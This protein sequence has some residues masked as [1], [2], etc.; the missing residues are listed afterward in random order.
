[1]ETLKIPSKTL[2]NKPDPAVK[3]AGYLGGL[4][5]S[6]VGSADGLNTV[7]RFPSSSATGNS[8]ATNS[9]IAAI[10]IVVGLLGFLDATYLTIGH[11][12]GTLPPCTIVHGCNQVLTSQYSTFVGVP[13]A[14]GGALYYLFIFI[15]ALLYLDT[16]RESA[17]ALAAQATVLGLL[18]SAYFLGLQI[19]IIRAYCLY[20]LGSII[21]STLLFIAAR[22]VKKSPNQ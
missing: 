8:R 10:F 15:S 11:Y 22:F 14:L 9:I 1:M 13:V 6:G 7:A 17:L 16:K 4:F 5:S 19:F 18:A 12:R 2:S 21:T 20:C 3:T